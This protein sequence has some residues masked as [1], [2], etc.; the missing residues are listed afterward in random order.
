MNNFQNCTLFN[1]G[2][3]FKNKYAKLIS[4]K[5]NIVNAESNLVIDDWYSVGVKPELV[6]TPV[7]D[8][9]N[10]DDA[11]SPLLICESGLRASWNWRAQVVRLLHGLRGVRVAQTVQLFHGLRGVCVAQTVRGQLQ[12][13][14]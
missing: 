11:V 4:T 2:K 6:Q 1:I 8:P 12:S 3:H 9:E 7:D 5:T 10:V 13:Q 14:S